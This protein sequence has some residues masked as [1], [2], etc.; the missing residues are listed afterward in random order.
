MAARDPSFAERV[1]RRLH[2]IRTSGYRALRPEPAEPERL[3]ARVLARV[4]ELGRTYEDGN[5][6]LLGYTYHPIPFDGFEHLNTHRPECEARLRAI[7]REVTIRPG[8]WVLDVGANVEAY[9]PHSA[10]FEIG[11][12]LSKLYKRDVLYINRGL[13]EAGLKYLRPRYRAI[14]LLSVFHWV[15]K[16]DGDAAA[17]RVLRDLAGRADVL[18]FEVPASPVDGMFHNREFVSRSAI[19]AY[20]A[21]VLPGATIVALSE[22]DAWAARP[23]YAIRHAG[24]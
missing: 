4:R 6:D 22:D 20:L 17:A 15:V 12:A 8:D 1:L 21:R 18:F 10:S 5:S 9:E 16:Q 23:L 11:A 13:S 19:E 2:R 14:L 3:R 7:L 24:A